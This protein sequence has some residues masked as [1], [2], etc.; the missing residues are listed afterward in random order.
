MSTVFGIILVVAMVGV[1]GYL[2]YG[3]VVDV[4]A[5]VKKKNNKK[6]EGE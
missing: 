5:K 3:I 6:G 1:V 4:I 2:G